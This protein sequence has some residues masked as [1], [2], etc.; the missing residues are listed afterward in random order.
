VGGLLAKVFL[1]KLI[2]KYDLRG[3]S[4]IPASEDDQQAWARYVGFQA[5]YLTICM[6][7]FAANTRSTNAP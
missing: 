1:E 5:N 2:K 3:E 6:A 7:G 4:C